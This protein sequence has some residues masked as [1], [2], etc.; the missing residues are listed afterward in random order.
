METNH[1]EGGYDRMGLDN[2]WKDEGS[3]VMEVLGGEPTKYKRVVED[4]LTIKF[5]VE[6]WNRLFNVGEGYIP[7]DSDGKTYTDTVPIHIYFI[8]KIEDERT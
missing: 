1:L 5:T 8:R 2:V 4:K 3:R 6:E 7:C